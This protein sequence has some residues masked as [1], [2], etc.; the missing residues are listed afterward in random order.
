MRGWMSPPPRSEL[1]R[2]KSSTAR[3]RNSVCEGSP[4]ARRPVLRATQGLK[5]QSALLDLVV[6]VCS[7]AALPVI[8][9]AA[10]ASRAPAGAFERHRSSSGTSCRF[11]RRRAA[12][13]VERSSGA[14]TL[15]PLVPDRER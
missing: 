2:R 6:R 10:S 8:A 3:S 1:C 15:L 9:T 5:E 11:L 4:A 13:R 14:A 12:G 7:R